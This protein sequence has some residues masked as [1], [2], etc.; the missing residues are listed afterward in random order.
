MKNIMA[1]S[2]YEMEILHNK[3]FIIDDCSLYRWEIYTFKRYDKFGKPVYN[4][5]AHVQIETSEYDPN[6]F[7]DTGE[8]HQDYIKCTP[9]YSLQDLL[10]KMPKTIVND[11]IVYKMIIDFADS[12]LYY[13]S[14]ETKSKLFE[15]KFDDKISSLIDVLFETL[16]CII[17]TK[18]YTEE[19]YAKNF[20]YDFE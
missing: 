3:G 9:I 18:I 10:E 13:Y 15:S 11:N 2:P 12:T 8:Y 6:D 16:C 14:G 19:Y 5:E 17:D 7:V 4:R 20:K 1:L